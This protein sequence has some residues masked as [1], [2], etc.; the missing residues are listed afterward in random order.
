M[1]CPLHR[2]R[3]RLIRRA[4]LHAVLLTAAASR[5]EHSLLPSAPMLYVGLR[6]IGDTTEQLQVVRCGV[7]ERSG[8]TGT[9]CDVI[10]MREHVRRV[11]V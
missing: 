6:C 11:T 10:C 7:M 9:G 4:V 2:L 3:L 1:I 8:A 5:I